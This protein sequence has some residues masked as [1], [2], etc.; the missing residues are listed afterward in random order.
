MQ[1]AGIQMV[2]TAVGDRY[3][4][5]AMRAGKYVLGGE[6][7]GHIILFDHA[8]TGD[9]VLTGLQL[10][11]VMA[12]RA[13]PLAGLAAVMTKYPQVLINVR[14]VDKA[15][16]AASPEVA[17]ATA[18]EAS[19]TARCSGSQ[20]GRARCSLRTSGRARRSASGSRPRAKRSTTR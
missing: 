4:I 20:G 13:E 11:A 3:L 6:Q 19:S 5:E 17:T 1:E 18:R 10:L 9:G 8:T 14:G 15:R 2:E 7:S 12:R 16:V